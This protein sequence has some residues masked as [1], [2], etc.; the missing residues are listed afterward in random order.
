MNNWMRAVAFAVGLGCAQFVSSSECET[1]LP[2]HKVIQPEG[3]VPA[4]RA[5]FVGTWKGK[6]EGK[7]CHT[8]VVEWIADNEAQV[9]YSHGVYEPWGITKA[10]G[11][12]KVARFDGDKLV[13]PKFGNG[14][15]ARYRFEQ[16]GLR[17]RYVTARGGVSY[18][19][20]KKVQ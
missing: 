19:D 8:F 17:G 13:L 10:E 9:I 5:R 18:V 15:R 14:A 4:D 1:P 2:K 11:I 7:L 12:R 6:W 20:L 16:G 3:D